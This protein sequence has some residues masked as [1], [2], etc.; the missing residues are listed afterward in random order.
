MLRRSS[1][2]SDDS[3]GNRIAVPCGTTFPFGVAQVPEIAAKRFRQ[4]NRETIHR[5]PRRFEGL[6]RV[7]AT[8]LNRFDGWPTRQRVD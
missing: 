3:S 7:I 6:R 4:D 8:V 5:L 2:Q 1:T